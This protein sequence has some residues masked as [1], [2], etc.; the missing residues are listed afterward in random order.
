MGPP[1]CKLFNTEPLALVVLNSD[2][3]DRVTTEPTTQGSPQGDHLD[4]TSP[5]R[6]RRDGDSERR[7]D[8]QNLEACILNLHCT[9]AYSALRYSHNET[10]FS[11]LQLLAPANHPPTPPTKIQKSSTV[12]GNMIL[13]HH[14]RKRKI[15]EPKEHKN[16]TIDNQKKAPS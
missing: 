5:F 1:R 6:S 12:R 3:G 2:K 4:R 7:W 11:L 16:R 14:C 13:R 10:H 15:R 8:H 9:F